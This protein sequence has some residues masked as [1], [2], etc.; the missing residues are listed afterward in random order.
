MHTGVES[1]KQRK[2]RRSYS[3]FIAHWMIIQS[4][5]ETSNSGGFQWDASFLEPLCLKKSW[6]KWAPV[7]Y[8]A[9]FSRSRKVRLSIQLVLL[10]WCFIRNSKNFSGFNFN[11]WMC[12]AVFGLNF[13]YSSFLIFKD[14]SNFDSK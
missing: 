13:T 8:R 4:M 14:W 12:Y 10:I 3:F 1:G 7:Y 2:C 6:Q 9:C 11:L 5:Q